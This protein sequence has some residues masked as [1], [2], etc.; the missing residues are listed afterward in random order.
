MRIPDAVQRALDKMM[1]NA[2]TCEGAACVIESVYQNPPKPEPTWDELLARLIAPR[3]VARQ[4]DPWA[5]PSHQYLG[6]SMTCDWC[7]QIREAVNNKP[8]TYCCCQRSCPRQPGDTTH[9]PQCPRYVT[10]DP[11]AAVLKALGEWYDTAYPDAKRVYL[12]PK[13]IEGIRKILN[14]LNPRSGA[15]DLHDAREAI[16]LLREALV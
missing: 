15:L 2:P 6:S 3:V 11:L 7:K 5:C 12:H 9:D 1:G 10:P 14:C 13:Q 16:R 8:T 4:P